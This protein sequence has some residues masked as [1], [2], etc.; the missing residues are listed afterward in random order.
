MGV[1]Q[2]VQDQPIADPIGVLEANHEIDR[3]HSVRE[4]LLEGIVS[5]VVEAAQAQHSLMAWSQPHSTTHDW[6]SLLIKVRSA[7]HRMNRRSARVHLRRLLKALKPLEVL[8]VPIRLGGDP[9]HFCQTRLVRESIRRLAEDLPW[10]G[11]F[12]ETADLIRVA[13]MMERNGRRDSRQVTEFE[14]IFTAGYRS[15]LEVLI[16]L[17]NE[18][19][20]TRDSDELAAIHVNEVVSR[21]SHIWR[22]HVS[23]VRISE[24]EVR[25]NPAAWT[26]T[27]RFI[28]KYGRELF[29]PRFMQYGNLRGILA[30]GID[31][32][33]DSL[34]HADGD[35][36]EQMMADLE[37]G[38]LRRD[39]AS[40]HLSFI[41]TV[42]VNHYDVFRDYTA[43][44]TQSDYGENLFSLFE[45]LRVSVDYDNH[46]WLVRP[47]LFAH[48]ALTALGRQQAADYLQLAMAEELERWAQEHVR[49]LKAVEN[50]YG[51]R[52]A[53]IN[54]KIQERFTRGFRLDRVL[55][56]VEP[57]IEN[58][59]STDVFDDFKSRLAE[60]VNKPTGS[61]FE[62]PD[63]A[64]K[65]RDE[66]QR[67]MEKDDGE[68]CHRSRKLPKMRRAEWEAQLKDWDDPGRA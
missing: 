39:E 61:G 52:L 36:P 46:W 47:A 34:A 38:R 51:V 54:D 13:R 23:S 24:I 35:I 64:N 28:E 66:I 65:L 2:A 21:F 62:P 1:M 57:A 11:L 9:L 32:F 14:S 45:L 48:R 33:L 29:T 49:A 55:A 41:L 25:S 43:T 60:F 16:R 42:V 17:L 53:S 30:Q 40:G 3:Q 56:L 63:W 50:K 20:D 44:T 7:V 59:A 67:V 26:A 31:R 15:V 18:W 22:E 19:K 37:S 12:R 4:H 6:E 68:F 27:K 8:Y 10:L 58:N 5:C